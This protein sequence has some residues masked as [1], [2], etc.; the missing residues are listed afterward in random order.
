MAKQNI[1]FLGAV[2][3][4]GYI[5]L[6]LHT[7]FPRDSIHSLRHECTLNILLPLMITREMNGPEPELLGYATVTIQVNPIMTSALPA[8]RAERPSLWHRLDWHTSII[9]GL[10]VDRIAPPVLDVVQA[11][12]TI[13]RI[14]QSKEYRSG[15]DGITSIQSSG[16]HIWRKRSW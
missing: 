2:T 3:S 11:D 14:L 8:R 13:L 1:F 7:K 6:Y 10:L 16:Q 5:L 12:G 9:R 15:T 4:K